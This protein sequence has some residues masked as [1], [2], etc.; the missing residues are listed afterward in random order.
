MCVTALGDFRFAH[1]EG[2]NDAIDGTRED[3]QNEHYVVQQSS[4]PLFR[5][6]GDALLRTQYHVQAG[7]RHLQHTTDYKPRVNTS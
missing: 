4:S 1:V 7:S 2:R 6:A 3:S 5:L